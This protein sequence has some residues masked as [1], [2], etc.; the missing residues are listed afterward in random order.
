MDGLPTQLGQRLSSNGKGRRGCVLF[1]A[2][3]QQY[4]WAAGE[5]DS[6]KPLK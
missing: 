6:W 4:V 5:K 2:Y 3:G 1:S